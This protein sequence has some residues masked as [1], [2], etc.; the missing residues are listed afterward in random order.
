MICFRLMN[1]DDFCFDPAWGVVVGI[2]PEAGVGIGEVRRFHA[3]AE[4]SADDS[5]FGASDNDE[6]RMIHVR[7]D[8]EGCFGFGAAAVLDVQVAGGVLP[9]RDLFARFAG[10]ISKPRDDRAFVKW[11]RREVAESGEYGTLAGEN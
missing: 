11:R 4:F 8:D 5:V 3:A 1:I 6:A 9:K 7:F 10:P 2:E